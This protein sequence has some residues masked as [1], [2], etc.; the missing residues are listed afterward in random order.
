VAKEFVTAASGV[1]DPG[2]LVLSEF[3][4]AAEELHEAILINPFDP[5]G[6]ADAIAEAL[7]MDQDERLRRI[8]RMAARTDRDNVYVWAEAILRRTIG[9]A[10]FGVHRVA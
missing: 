10:R 8:D 2:M 9:A 3:A 4:G 5:D 7:T 1:D 6:V